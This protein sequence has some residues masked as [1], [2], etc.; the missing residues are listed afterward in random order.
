[1]YVYLVNQ[2]SEKSLECSRLDFSRLA[3]VRYR[4]PGKHET[5]EVV[6]RGRGGSLD[7]T[8]EC[9]VLFKCALTFGRLTFTGA[10]LQYEIFSCITRI[11]ARQWDIYKLVS[12]LVSNVNKYVPTSN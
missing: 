10:N 7:L 1:M 3:N 6:D 9:N 4:L 8:H 5:P 2:G 12:N 11:R